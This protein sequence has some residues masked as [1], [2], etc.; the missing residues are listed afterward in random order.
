MNQNQSETNLLDPHFLLQKNFH[1]HPLLL[2]LLL[3]SL[4]RRQLRRRR[5]HHRYLP[6]LKVKNRL[7]VVL[8][9]TEV[10]YIH[11]MFDRF[12]NTKILYSFV[13][14]F[15]PFAEIDLTFST[16]ELTVL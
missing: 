5:R 12:G 4:V 15:I 11:R 10:Y 8:D 1:H 7:N 16:L 14:C 6:P 2:R 9:G 13:R 3:H